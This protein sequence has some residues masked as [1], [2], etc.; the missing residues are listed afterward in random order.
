[1]DM[2][3]LIVILFLFAALVT[4]AAAVMNFLATAQTPPART[5]R[6]IPEMT[7]RSLQNIAY[8]LLLVLMFGV[9]TGWM[10]GG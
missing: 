6:G 3:R 4:A 8:A 7:T 1:M 9:V 10:S 2:A 5:R